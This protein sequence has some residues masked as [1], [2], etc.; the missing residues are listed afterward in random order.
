MA[1][2]KEKLSM[3]CS[4]GEKCKEKCGHK[5]EHAYNTGCKNMCIYV[6][7][8]LPCKPVKVP[9]LERWLN[10]ISRYIPIM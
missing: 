8:E 1:K 9:L 10:K 3:K 6:D 2:E 7:F 4:Y 5:E